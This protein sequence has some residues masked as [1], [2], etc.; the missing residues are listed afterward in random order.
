MCRELENTLDLTRVTSERHGAALAPTR[1]EFEQARRLGV[2]IHA[3]RQTIRDCF[4]HS[5]NGR[6]FEAALAD[7]GFVLAQGDR[8][9]FV[10][11]GPRGRNPRTREAHSGCDGGPDP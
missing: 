7:H 9:D 10:V 5:D 4:E 2:D 8:R 11:I 1:D 3:V 6:S